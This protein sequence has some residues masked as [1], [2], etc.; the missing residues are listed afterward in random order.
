M[1][2]CCCCCFCILKCWSMADLGILICYRSTQ[3]PTP[4]DFFLHTW[5]ISDYVCFSH[6]NIRTFW[7]NKGPRPEFITTGKYNCQN[8]NTSICIGTWT[9]DTSIFGMQKYKSFNYF[10]KDFLKIIYLLKIRVA[11]TGRYMMRLFILWF[12]PWMATKAR[13]WPLW[14][15]EPGTS[16]KSP[17]F[18]AQTQVLGSL[19]TSF[20][21]AT[22]GSWMETRLAGILSGAP[23]LDAYMESFS[24]T[25][26]ARIFSHI[27]QWICFT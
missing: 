2:F 20:P 8:A 12:T 6:N 25:C 23:I 7:G 9:S 21:G 24:L 4:I 18:V 19:T 13:T 14:S 15:Q 22:A 11:K 3:L 5:M 27:E 26:C 17:M 16:P 1:S 10:A